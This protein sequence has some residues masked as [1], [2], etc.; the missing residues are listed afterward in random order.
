M[1]K[2]NPEEIS[3]NEYLDKEKTTIL[4][5]RVVPAQDLKTIEE[6]VVSLICTIGEEHC[7]IIR[8]DS[9]KKEPPNVHR[10][11]NKP[12]TKQYIEKDKSFETVEELMNHIRENWANYLLRY[13]EKYNKNT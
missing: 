1:V 4:F 5:I 6:F 8:F 11:Y 2:K 12:P 13:K 7:E 9:T 10:F 3:L